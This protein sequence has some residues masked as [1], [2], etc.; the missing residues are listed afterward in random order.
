VGADTHTK[1]QETAKNTGRSRLYGLATKPGFFTVVEQSTAWVF[2]ATGSRWG[3]G[4]ASGSTFVGLGVSSNVKGVCDNLM[5]WSVQVGPAFQHE[6][7]VP[8]NDRTLLRVDGY[9]SVSPGRGNDFTIYAAWRGLFGNDVFGQNRVQI[10]VRTGVI[11]GFAR[12]RIIPD[13]AEQINLSGQGFNERVEPTWF[14]GLDGQLNQ[15]QTQSYLGLSE[16]FYPFTFAIEFGPQFVQTR[17]RNLQTI[18]GSFFDV[19]H[20]IN[21]RTRAYVRYRPALS[22]GGSDYPAANQLLVAGVNHR[23]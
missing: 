16:T 5:T 9:W 13:A 1:S 14:F 12:S 20:A 15:A 22:F 21:G 6:Y 10:T 3:T 23:F 19:G 2:P 8:G 11:Y 7:N 17:N 4:A 18:L